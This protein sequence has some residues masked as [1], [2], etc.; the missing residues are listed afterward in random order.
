MG[1]EGEDFVGAASLT[2]EA[3]QV[4]QFWIFSTV[5]GE[6]QKDRSTVSINQLHIQLSQLAQLLLVGPK[7]FMPKHMHLEHLA[8]Y[9]I[10]K[11]RSLLVEDVFPCSFLPAA[12]YPVGVLHQLGAGVGQM[13][14][15]EGSLGFGGDV[16]EV[17]LDPGPGEGLDFEI[18]GLEVGVWV[19]DQFRGLLDLRCGHV[20]LVVLGDN[21]NLPPWA[22]LVSITICEARYPHHYLNS[23]A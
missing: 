17:V 23:V 7:H 12:G 14:E 22:S 8:Q 3:W 1:E 4:R 18:A 10:H 20:G 16:G 19:R 21:F 6:G 11:L 15:V 13:E 9:T 5:Q 2:V